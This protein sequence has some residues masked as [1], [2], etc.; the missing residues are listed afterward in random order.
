MIRHLSLLI[1]FV[2]AVFQA[3]AQSA[4]S[5][6][7]MPVYGSR[8]EKLIDTGNRI[9][10]LTS[11]NLYGYDT[12]TEEMRHYNKLNGLNDLNVRH[13]AYNNKKG[14][15]VIAYNSSNIDLLYDNGRVVNIPDIR[16]AN[17]SASKAI[18]DISFADGR[19]YLATGFGFVA[20][21]DATHRVADSGIYGSNFNYAGQIK[22]QIMLVSNCAVYA[23][24]K[25][26]RHN[27]FD[28]FEQKGFLSYLDKDICVFGDK[29]VLSTSSKGKVGI[30]DMSENINTAKYTP[31]SED[32][33]I[34]SSYIYT[35]DGDV[36]LATS[37]G[38]R[39]FSAADGSWTTAELPSFFSNKTLAM[40]N[41]LEGNIWASDA[42]GIGQYKVAGGD[43]TTLRSPSRP[44]ALTCAWPAFMFLSPDSK[45][46]YVTNVGYEAYRVNTNEKD[47]D[48]VLQ[49]T[50]I[51]EDGV[52][53]DVSC[54]DW[55]G[56]GS[57]LSGSF[58]HLAQDPND[59]SRY[60][61]A[62]RVKGIYVL[63]PEDG[64]I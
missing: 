45:R 57:Q 15:L 25:D 17:I 51:I 40:N 11:G 22:D 35:P 3:G 39:L 33:T 42:D 30:L 1:L 58:Q 24:D 60:F 43:V 31:V 5:W 10:T 16:D 27:S 61:I 34:L 62:S 19:I 50:N 7:L 26:K 29:Y 23:S 8:A 28:S 56:K 49:T 48:N 9:Y 47:K 44:E 21:D 59:P 38:V 41:G 20:I 12:A 46:I 54:Y 52:I 37:G 53:R 18:N 32:E 64:S 55:D 63:S 6:E 13:I 14:Y 36:Y 2:A 4:G